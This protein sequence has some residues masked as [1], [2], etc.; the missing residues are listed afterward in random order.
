MTD[1]LSKSD[2][3][4]NMSKIRGK[5]TKLEILVRKELFKR[6]KRY[7]L[8]SNLPGKPD[9]VFLPKKVA[10]F[11][12]GCFWHQHG[13]SLSYMPKTNVDFW[14]TKLNKNKER[15]KNVREKLKSIGWKFID[16]WE[17]EIEKDIRNITDMICNFTR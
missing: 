11:V 10:V 2:R 3:S 7:M 15:D 9:I 6:G 16:V 1:R 5:N 14:K 12:N 17:C 8:N 13:C 4:V